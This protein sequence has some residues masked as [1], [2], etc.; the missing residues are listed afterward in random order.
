MK[1]TFVLHQEHFAPSTLD[2]MIKSGLKIEPVP[3]KI[4]TAQGVDENVRRSK[5]RWI[6]RDNE[7][8]STV[9]P[10]FDK[11]FHEANRKS[12][13]FDIQWLP[14]IQFT[15]Y[16]AESQGHYDW[17]VDV[18]WET[19]EFYQRKLS[20]VVQLSDPGDYEGGE[21]QLDEWKRPDPDLLKKR[22]SVI[23]FPSFIKHRVTPVTKGIRRSLV[24]WIE[25]PLWR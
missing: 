7:D 19:Q 8:Y 11:M 18:F 9:F 12:F 13:G 25:G 24:A 14:S 1:D 23:I 22:G 10:V 4:G 17:H 20:M 5:L 2:E 16:P 3:A 6:Q 21:L 15:E